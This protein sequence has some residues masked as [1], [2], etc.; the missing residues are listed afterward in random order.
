M[1]DVSKNSFLLMQKNCKSSGGKLP[2]KIEFVLPSVKENFALSTR[3]SFCRQ[4]LYRYGV[5]LFRVVWLTIPVLAVETAILNR[6][7]DMLWQNMFCIAQIGN[8]TRYF[9][10]PVKSPSRQP[11]P[12]HSS[13]E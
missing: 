13:L 6:F 1:R 7:A 5:F 12:R 8:G 2:A 11:E 3:T 9:A 10:N 4:K